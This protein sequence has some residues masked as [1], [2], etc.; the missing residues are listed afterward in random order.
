MTES[1]SKSLSKSMTA[2]M[3]ASMANKSGKHVVPI[4]QKYSKVSSMAYIDPSTR[5]KPSDLIKPAL[6]VVAD[7]Y[8][9]IIEFNNLQDNSSQIHCMVDIDQP[10]FQPSPKIVL[11]EDYTPFAVQEKKLFFRNNDSVS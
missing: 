4:Y 10:L 8:P 7:D 6:D 3:S 1:V 2:S 9:M 11:F 5:L